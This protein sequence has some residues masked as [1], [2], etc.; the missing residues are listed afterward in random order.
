[1]NIKKLLILFSLSL[2]LTACSDNKKD[3]GDNIPLTEEIETVSEEEIEDDIKNKIPET[4]DDVII[5]VNKIITSDKLY[6]EQYV[7]NSEGKNILTQKEFINPK[8]DNGFIEMIIGN[9]NMLSI[10]DSIYYTNDNNWKKIT[11]SSGNLSKSNIIYIFNP[12]TIEIK[13]IND[14]NFSGTV[15]DDDGNRYTIDCDF[16]NKE[17]KIKND[18]SD[19]IFIDNS[20][21]NQYIVIKDLTDKENIIPDIPDKYTE[22]DFDEYYDVFWNETEASGLYDYFPEDE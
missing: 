7:T 8:E 14:K 4:E 15:E 13:D 10:G 21:T 2:L 5:F 18:I 3:I 22:S 17:I 6:S 19:E 16:N 11:V 20:K 9:L 12:E 1:M